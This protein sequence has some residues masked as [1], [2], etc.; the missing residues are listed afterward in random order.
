VLERKCGSEQ[1]A[2]CKNE[3]RENTDTHVHTEIHSPT[4][5]RR[6]GFKAPIGLERSRYDRGFWRS[7]VGDS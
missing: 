7:I 5:L 1:G 4:S 2:D 3:V 6:S